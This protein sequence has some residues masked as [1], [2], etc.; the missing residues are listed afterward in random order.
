MQAFLFF[1]TRDGYRPQEGKVDAVKVEGGKNRAEHI[2]KIVDGG[3]A[4]VG[5]V[6]L[7]PQAIRYLK[8]YEI[9]FKQSQ[10]VP[11]CSCTCIPLIAPYEGYMDVSEWGKCEE[12]TFQKHQRRK[13]PL[14]RNAKWGEFSLEVLIW[15]FKSTS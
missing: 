6:G 12:K 13:T 7:T 8:Y 14:R 10:L 5:H 3:I 2:R 15:Y 1:F 4:V 9:L 11:H